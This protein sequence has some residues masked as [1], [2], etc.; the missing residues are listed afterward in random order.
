MLPR[1]PEDVAICLEIQKGRSTAGT[2]YNS[3][4]LKSSKNATQAP[5]DGCRSSCECSCRHNPRKN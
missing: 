5:V 4:L 1:A 3:F 2:N